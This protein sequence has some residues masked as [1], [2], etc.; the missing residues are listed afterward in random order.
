MCE[1]CAFV[2]TNRK[3][4]LTHMK[5][6]HLDVFKQ[7]VEEQRLQRK[8]LNEALANVSSDDDESTTKSTFSPPNTIEQ[9]HQ[10]R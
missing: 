1:Y 3:D 6:D 2:S 10:V 5:S 4:W 9:Q 8:V 7:L